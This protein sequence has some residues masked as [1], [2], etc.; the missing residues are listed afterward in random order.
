M[1][2]TLATL[3]LGASLLTS[4]SSK[5]TE[6]KISPP[7]PQPVVSQ[8]MVANDRCDAVRDLMVDTVVHQ[9]VGGGVNATTGFDG[10][11]IATSDMA[12]AEPA[13]ES[14][15]PTP[16][17]SSGQNTAPANPSHYTTTNVQENNVDEGDLVK[18]DGK[19]VYTL[20]NGEL[21]I[22]KTWP[23]AETKLTSR[24]QF[25]N[26]QAQQL[27]L[28]GDKVIVHGVALDGLHPYSQGTTR[29]AVI[30]VSDRTAPKLVRTF[31]VDG[32]NA[33]SRVIDGDLYLVQN[34][35]IA[36]P[37]KLYEL[38]QQIMAKVPRADSM[39]LR[40]WEIQSRIAK[41]MRQT[42]L[43]NLSVA[44]IAGSLPKIYTGGATSTMK[45]AD[46]YMP[47]SN[48]GL[49]I[50][51]LA[52]IT[53]DNQRNDLVGAMVTG[54]QVYA[55]TESVYVAAPAYTW[56][57]QGS[58]AYQTQIHQFSLTKNDGRPT[59]VATGAVDGQLLNQ[60]SMSELNGD[61][62]VATTDWN[63]QGQQGGNHLFVMRTNDRTLET[64]GSIRG[65]AKGERIY[66][67]RMFGDKGYLVTF[68]QT[69]PLFTLDLSD[70]RHPRVAGELEINGFSNYIHPM[71]NDL[72]LAIGQDADDNGRMQ[73]FHMQVFDV[74]DPSKPTRRFHEKLSSWSNYS[75]SAAQ[76]DHHAFTYDPVTGTLALPV[77]GSTNEGDAF[78]ALVVYHIDPKT[79]FT[80][81][82]R[83]TH[84]ELAA[85]LFAA[86]CGSDDPWAQNG[87]C[88]PSS[89]RYLI[90]AYSQI[91][92]SIVVDKYLMTIG[93]SGMEIHQLDHLSLRAAQLRWPMPS[94]DAAQLVVSAD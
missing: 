83:V 74:K 65:L 89:R 30:D 58:A 45:C 15:A 55:S 79:G 80:L 3:A 61:L 12:R 50:T 72:L 11:A 5:P 20:R 7:V 93:Q 43:D 82:G 90:P 42:L 62:R 86:N 23:V 46:L 54:G 35:G 60:F 88:D 67:G 84:R 68:R 75:A 85:E 9:T 52:R 48:I 4:C 8:T 91:E 78:N 14:K 6:S 64:I 26:L 24:I 56:N 53:I 29:V 28:Q 25:K 59:Y 19:F 16:S 41:S 37:P 94:V 1:R 87:N 73:G 31:D 32:Q 36:V 51:A 76:A 81:H 63:W 57:E 22:A 66:A 44:D 71:G 69:D 10:R 77:S 17:A 33:S 38:A 2:I 47:Q 34:G 39:S 70:P 27:Y 49:G 21:F 92:R 40:P 13:A 18:T